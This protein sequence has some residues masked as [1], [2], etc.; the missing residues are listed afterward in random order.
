MGKVY[1]SI[2]DDFAVWIGEQ[3]LFMVGT[4]PSSAG[5]INMSPKGYDSFRILSP[6]C[7]AYADLTGTGNETA[8][9]LLDNG[10]ITF[11]FMSFDATAR[12][13]RL[14]GTGEVIG[15]SDPRFSDLSHHFQRM[16]GVRQI[17]KADI[18]RLQCSAI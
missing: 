8:A 13:L 16:A 4:A 5:H 18:L 15:R 9:H 2:A 6:N 7:V 11:L 12:I 1:D 14:Y 3:K 17:I 10:R